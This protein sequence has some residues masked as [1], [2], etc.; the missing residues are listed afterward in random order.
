MEASK[1]KA[2]VGVASAFLK[3]KKDG[4][5]I[6]SITS[7]LGGSTGM[8]KFHQSYPESTID[9][10]VAESNMVS[11]AAGFSKMVT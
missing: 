1:E 2:Q 6:V 5:P 4:L 8:G 11:V 9:V 7:D 10:G 3:L